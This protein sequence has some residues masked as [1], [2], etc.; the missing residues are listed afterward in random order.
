MYGQLSAV[1]GVTFARALA[2]AD[3]L[4]AAPRVRA[5]VRR[6]HLT[7]QSARWHQC[8]V[9]V[10]GRCARDGTH[11]SPRQWHAAIV[12]RRRC[13]RRRHRAVACAHWLV[14]DWDGQWQCA[15]LA[16]AAAAVGGT[17]AGAIVSVAAPYYPC[18]PRARHTVRGRK[19]RHGRVAV[20]GVWLGR[21]CVAN[22]S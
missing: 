2:G 16:V 14:R 19:C 21:V 8:R 20:L 13:C 7:P 18:R 1:G 15:W 12:R 22:G 17:A 11:R 9:A 4:L 6:P 3:P 10:H 5:F